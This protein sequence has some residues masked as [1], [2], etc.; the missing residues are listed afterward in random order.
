MDSP[1]LPL[2]LYALA[3]AATWGAADFAGGLATKRGS[4]HTVIL[5]S[6]GLGLALLAGCA[7]AFGEPLPSRRDTLLAVGCGTASAVGLVTLYRSLALGRMG[8]VAPVAAVVAAVIP[9]MAGLFLEGPPS[10]LQALG[11]GLATISVWLVSGTE[12]RGRVPARAFA[13]PVLAGASFALLFILID[14]MSDA[15]LF[16]PLA[17][18]RAV[19]LG[20]IGASALARRRW[21][22]PRSGALA[23]MILTGVFDGIGNVFFVLATHAGRLDVSAML[24]SLYPAATVFLARIFLRERLSRRQWAGMVSASLALAFIAS[25]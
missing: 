17:A 1:N 24:S 15:A 18:A 10:R 13:L 23:V 8:F 3:T 9:A 6:Q 5:V 14:R 20:W 2:V 19:S 11:F 21:E 22:S 25:S 12:G 4:V 7:L 16:W